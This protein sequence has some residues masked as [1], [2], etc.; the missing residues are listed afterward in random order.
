MQNITRNAMRNQNIEL[1]FFGIWERSE[2]FIREL[3]FRLVPLGF[4]EHRFE[5]F[6]AMS[7]ASYWDTAQGIL[8]TM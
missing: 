3:T 7:E 1:F 4:I 5:K 2:V 6:L 8:L